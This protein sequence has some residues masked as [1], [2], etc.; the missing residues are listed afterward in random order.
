M[1]K[2]KTLYVCTECG[3]Q[4]AKWQGQCPHC[5]AWNTLVEGVAEAPAAA[6][7]ASQSLARRVAGAARSPTSRRPRCRASRP[8]STSSIACSAAGSSPG[9]RRADRRRPGHRQVDAAAAGAVAA[10]GDE[11]DAV[12]QRRGVGRADRAARAA[13]RRRRRA[14]SAASATCGCSPRSTSRR[15]R[16]AIDARAARRR[17]DRL[18]P[19]PVFRRA[20]V[21]ARLGRA[22]AR[23][24]GAA[25]A[26]REAARH[27][28]HPRRPR[29]E[30]GHARR[31]ARARAHRRHGAV[32][33]GRHALELPARARDQEPLRRG[34]R[35]RRVRD[36]R[37]RAEGRVESVGAVPVAARAG[38]Q[39]RH[40]A[41][42]VRAR[43]AGR[44]AAAAGRDPGAG[45]RRRTTRTRGGC[46]SASSRTG[47]RC[48]SRC[49]IVTP[50][51]RATTRT[52]SSTRSAA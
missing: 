23:V 44:H 30:G 25:D 11:E 38:R 15:S 32:L 10:V 46:R 45:R 26:H 35:A 49:C 13:A 24:R 7:I 43:H 18:D 52:C 14:A 9:A 5:Q 33:R 42:L 2:A 8:A 41:G 39:G 31:A 28:D 12:R 50:A 27:D 34:Q 37:A 51:S 36:D 22:G 20:D 17:G 1:A 40:G 19:D 6:R 3:G 16:R 47:S 21:G 4:T 48:C 29:D